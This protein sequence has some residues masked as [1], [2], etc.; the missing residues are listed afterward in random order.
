MSE[1]RC[2]LLFLV[3]SYSFKVHL[4]W[5]SKIRRKEDRRQGRYSAWPP[6]Q[7]LGHAVDVVPSAVVSVSIDTE[8]FIL[9]TKLWAMLRDCAVKKAASPGI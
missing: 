2:K 8:W 6:P 7:A 9:Q 3:A 4:A 1:K 5:S